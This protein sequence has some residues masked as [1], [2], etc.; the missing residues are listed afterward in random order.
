MI[1]LEHIVMVQDSKIKKNN[2][3]WKIGK[4]THIEHYT[5]FMSIVLSFRLLV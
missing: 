5:F 1:H 2:N 3:Y 4:E